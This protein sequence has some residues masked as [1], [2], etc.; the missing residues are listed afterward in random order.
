MSIY[1]RYDIWLKWSITVQKYTV[2]DNLYNTGLWRIMLVEMFINMI[3][4][5]PFLDGYIYE[6]D[7]LAFGTLIQYEV[8]DILLFFMFCRLYLGLKFI[9]YL[10]QFMNPRS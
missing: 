5:Y 3:A 2:Y 8:N 9:L 10:T 1:I 4:P 6:E 7:N